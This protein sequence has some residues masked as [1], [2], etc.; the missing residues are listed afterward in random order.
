VCS[1]GFGFYDASDVD[2][3]GNGG[4]DQGGAALAKQINRLSGIAS[5]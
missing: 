5:Q 1:C 3:A 2:L 4:G